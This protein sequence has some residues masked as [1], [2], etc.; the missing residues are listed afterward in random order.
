[1]FSKGN[2]KFLLDIT[3]FVEQQ[4]RGWTWG[5]KEPWKR[6]FHAAAK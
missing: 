5:S 1:M 4:S 3:T 2:D 6:C